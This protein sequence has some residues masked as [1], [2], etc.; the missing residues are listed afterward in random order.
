[1]RPLLVA[2]STMVMLPLAASRGAAQDAQQWTF[3]YGPVGQFTAGTIVGGVNDL[4]AVYYN[5]ATLSLMQE[6][7]FLLSL[8]TA[9]IS[10]I[11]AAGAAGRGL[12]LNTTVFH[13]RP[14]ML[15]GHLGTNRGQADHFAWALLARY[16]M[17]WDLEVSAETIGQGGGSAG[18][19]RVRERMLEYWGGV[20]WS[21]RL[22]PRLAFGVT[23]FRAYRIQRNRRILSLTDVN[24]A[25]SQQSF[26][27]RE[28]EYDHGRVL[29]KPALAWRPG[30]WELGANLTSPGLRLYDHG[31]AVFQAS[32]SG[33]STP[34]LLSASTQDGIPARYHAPWSVAAGAT[35]RFPRR[36]IH[37]SLEWFSSVAPYDI[38]TPQ[39]A[40]VTGDSRTIPLA[41]RG[42]AQSVLD[43]GAGL[44][45]RI[46][47]QLTLY[48]GAAHNGSSWL[49]DADTFA[50]W[51]LTHLTA[52]V[53]V[54]SPSRHARLAAGLGY[55]WGDGPLPPAVSS[56]F[57][58][59]PPP[60]P[61][62]RFWQLTGSVGAVFHTD[63]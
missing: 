1:M 30:N 48:L 22:R 49:K 9:E 50:S 37:A 24:D 5:P 15:A 46:G 3:G 40:P 61:R 27:A 62:S 47:E 33:P 63:E 8:N 25:A 18:F 19:G 31:K 17:D 55:A 28:N 52:G 10:K 32:L 44:E 21:H 60:A 20:A 38:L 42:G 51:S 14:G 35:R 26:V 4:S 34:A 23:T 45:Q 29:L 56:P 36:A 11:D 6:P 58:A 57:T 2:V 43:Y 54:R 13:L 59:A 39:D 16:D 7:R 53:S 41:Y 12:D